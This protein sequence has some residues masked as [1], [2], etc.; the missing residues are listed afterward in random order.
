MCVC[1]CVGGWVDGC[2]VYTQ[3]INC[4]TLLSSIITETPT[5]LLLYIDWV[6]TVSFV[7]KSLSTHI[8]RGKETVLLIHSILIC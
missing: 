6:I 3:L 5:A 8:M 1:L 4:H 7:C 2:T